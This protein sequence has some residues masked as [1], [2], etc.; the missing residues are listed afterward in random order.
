MNEEIATVDATTGLVT[1]KKA[2]SVTIKATKEGCTEGTIDLTVTEGSS[3]NPEKEYQF[4]DATAGDTIIVTVT[5]TPNT[6]IN[7]CFGYNDNGTGSTNGWYQDEFGNQTIGS[8]GTLTLKHTVRDTYTGGNI[9]FKV[10]HN[11]AAVS[12]VEHTVQHPVRTIT[13]T[14]SATTLKVGGTV[15]LT[16]DVDGVTYSSSNEQVAT[17]DANGVVTGVGAGSVTITATKNGYTDGTIALTVISD[18]G[19]S[20]GTTEESFLSLIHI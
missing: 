5:G 8:D 6:E 17:V 7:G 13:L 14:P 11:N 2:G 19:S 20:G 4:S 15:T 12:K 1:A 16:S 9:Y 10:W 3:E 18:G